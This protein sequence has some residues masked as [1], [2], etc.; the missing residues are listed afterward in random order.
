MT[1][2]LQAERSVFL[3]K[4]ASNQST[5]R[6]VIC[7]LI[8]LIAYLAPVLPESLNRHRLKR[9]YQGWLR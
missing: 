7:H 8:D 2:G 4:R 9:Y 1:Q 6:Y 3:A 5:G